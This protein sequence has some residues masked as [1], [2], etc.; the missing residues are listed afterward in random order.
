[1]VMKANK[2]VKFLGRKKKPKK[3]STEDGRVSLSSPP[4]LFFV[5]CGPCRLFLLSV[6]VSCVL[7]FK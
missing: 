5:L 4:P 3:K 2:E 6:S 7:P 1:M